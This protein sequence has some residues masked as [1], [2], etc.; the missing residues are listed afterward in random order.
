[1]IADPSPGLLSVI[2]CVRSSVTV[3]AAIFDLSMATARYD[4]VSVAASLVVEDLQG[5]SS[6]QLRDFHAAR[7]SNLAAAAAIALPR[8]PPLADDLEPLDD[9]LHASPHHDASH[10]SP[11]LVTMGWQCFLSDL[12]WLGLLLQCHHT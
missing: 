9:Y 12:S 4:S 6:A 10:G 11:F 5:L 7:G 8:E 3:A 2:A 1:M